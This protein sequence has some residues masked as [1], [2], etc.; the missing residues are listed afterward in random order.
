MTSKIRVD[1]ITNGGGNGPPNFPEGVDISGSTFDPT[2]FVSRVD[3]T[4]LD[5]GYTIT[6]KNDGTKS[7][8]TYTPDPTDANMITITNDGAFTLAAPTAAGS[9]TLIISVTNDSSAGAITLSGFTKVTGDAFTTTD[10][11]QFLL[12]ITKLGTIAHVQVQ[13]L[14]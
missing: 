12:F 6:A 4:G 10:T 2:D 8:G 3:D 11:E 13:S 7:S 1:E 14:Q 5:A 9:Y